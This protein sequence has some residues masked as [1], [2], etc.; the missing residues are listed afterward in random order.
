MDTS[1]QRSGGPDGAERDVVISRVVD[2]R[3]GD[4]EWAALRAMA[5]RDATIW[6]EL[7]EAQR[8]HR[9]LGEAM[10][11]ALAAAERA[12][13]PDL[14]VAG[15]ARA[16]PERMARV[17]WRAGLGWAA[18]AAV[19]LAWMAGVNPRGAAGPAAVNSASIV[20]I[21]TNPDELLSRYLDM[22]RR[23]GR[24]VAEM[25]ER[26]VLETRP[27]ADGT[28]T[29]VLFLRQVLERATVTDAAMFRVGVND[30]G[31]RVLVPAERVRSS[32]APSL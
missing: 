32:P 24:V 29:E 14:A 12:G 5:E 7:S 30:A 17:N 10:G 19:G 20:P 18:A 16:W 31:Q 13:L 6:A 21:N 22:G 28:G 25:P 11:P 27:L 4:G 15:A 1:T 26:V 3:A 9:L 2:G 8:Q 23:Q